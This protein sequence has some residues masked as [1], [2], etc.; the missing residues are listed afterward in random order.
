M[1][2]CEYTLRQWKKTSKDISIC[3]KTFQN[4]SKD[5]WLKMCCKTGNTLDN[6]NDIEN[7][8]VASLQE[9]RN[10]RIKYFT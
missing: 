10:L 7:K 6:S 8:N 2:N 9:L 5:N 1:T 3:L 4:I